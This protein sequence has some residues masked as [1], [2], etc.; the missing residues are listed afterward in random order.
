M[1][2]DW[3]LISRKVQ[4]LD[5]IFLLWKYFFI[6]NL[7]RISKHP[8]QLQNLSKQLTDRRGS[9]GNLDKNYS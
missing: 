2:E 8:V 5:L 1:E 6:S 7:I 3:F 9:A 4:K